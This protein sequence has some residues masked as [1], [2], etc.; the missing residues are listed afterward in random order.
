MNGAHATL[1]CHSGQNCVTC[2]RPVWGVRFVVL[3]TMQSMCQGC[4]AADTADLLPKLLVEHPLT[5]LAEKSVELLSQKSKTDEV[6]FTRTEDTTPLQCGNCDDSILDT[7]SYYSCANCPSDC[8]KIHCRSCAIGLS[9]RDA[10]RCT[11]VRYSDGH[12]MVKVPGRTAVQGSILPCVLYGNTDE[13]KRHLRQLGKRPK[14]TLTTSKQK[15]LAVRLSATT[16]QQLVATTVVQSTQPRHANLET[17]VQNSISA[18]I[19]AASS[20]IQQPASA[21]KAPKSFA[22]DSRW[23]VPLSTK[24]GQF[25]PS[26]MHASMSVYRNISAALGGSKRT[27]PPSSL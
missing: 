11:V 21:A 22:S 4:E 20:I 19:T 25:C 9:K 2:E 3:G 5:R 23:G 10:P 7:A 18:P 1:K 16:Q 17:A 13:L 15:F 26:N 14:K 12:L 27:S 8:R 24:Q 6:F